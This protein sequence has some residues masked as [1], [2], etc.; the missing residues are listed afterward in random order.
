MFM[1]E[2][3]IKPRKKKKLMFSVPTRFLFQ[4]RLRFSFVSLKFILKVENKKI[5]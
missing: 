1:C 3:G 4:G 5:F 2:C